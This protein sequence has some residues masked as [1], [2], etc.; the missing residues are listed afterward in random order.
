MLCILMVRLPT[1]IS[2]PQA[3]LG[4]RASA[5]PG[6][7][8]QCTGRPSTSSPYGMSGPVTAAL[9]YALEQVASCLAFCMLV[10][11]RWPC[12]WR[13]SV[14]NFVSNPF[15]RARLAACCSRYQASSS[16]C[17]RPA[18]GAPCRSRV[19]PPLRSSSRRCSSTMFYAHS[20][21]RHYMADGQ[22]SCG[23]TVIMCQTLPE[24]HTTSLCTGAL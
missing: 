12:Q 22:I 5:W 9:A 3:C 7:G 8:R 11:H 20:I 14:S 18:T 6:S 23:G 10:C 4:R 16:A 19:A 24:V 21:V 2:I 15:V 13:M 17:G 1:T